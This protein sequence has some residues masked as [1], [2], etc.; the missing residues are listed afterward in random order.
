LIGFLFS[1]RSLPF[2]R[3]LINT[4]DSVMAKKASTIS[5]KDLVQAKG[6]NN[7]PSIPVSKNTGRKEAITIKLIKKPVL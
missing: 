7:L 3:K 6:L 1:G 5:I 2:R 4:G